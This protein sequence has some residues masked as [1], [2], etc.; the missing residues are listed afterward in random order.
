MI[1][2]NENKKTFADNLRYYM[3][4][5]NVDRK[6]LS[7]DLDIKYSTLCEWLKATTSPRIDKIIAIAD[8]FEVSASVF[9]KERDEKVESDFL[10][11][12]FNNGNLI[13]HDSVD[14]AQSLINSTFKNSFGIVI[15]GNVIN[16]M[17]NY[18]DQDIVI[19]ENTNSFTTINS[20]YC[21]KK[22]DDSIEIVRL[23]GDEK[24][25]LLIP[26]YNA[27]SNYAPIV[28]VEKKIDFEVLGIAKKIITNL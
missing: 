14:S 9:F 22:H 28:L 3:Q 27:T 7:A 26:I 11:Y 23:I 19:F 15:T 21:I 5:N 25:Y 24:N 10:I 6:K 4:I 1:N 18:K 16:N 17:S 20:D 13:K 2:K 8:Y 12:E